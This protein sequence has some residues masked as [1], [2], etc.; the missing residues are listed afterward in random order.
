[1]DEGAQE[2]AIPA[3]VYIDGQTVDWWRPTRS[4]N[5]AEDYAAGARVFHEAQAMAAQNH[6]FGLL[7]SF[8]VA[9]REPRAYELGFLDAFAMAAA[10]CPAPC[11]YTSE[12]ISEQL[13]EMGFRDQY[14]RAREGL[15]FRQGNEEARLDRLA[16]LTDGPGAIVREI[17]LFVLHR[18]RP[19]SPAYLHSMSLAACRAALTNH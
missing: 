8:V 14:A 19:S 1:M 12:H 10:R 5:D 3:V 13:T 6:A 11:L 17:L 18:P 15:A 2:P 7:C 4:G 16:A 9:M